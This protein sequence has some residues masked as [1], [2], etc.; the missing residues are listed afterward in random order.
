[1]GSLH[2]VLFPNRMITNGL[3]AGLLECTSFDA[4][5]VPTVSAVRTVF[6][7]GLKDK[8]LIRKVRGSAFGV[9]TKLAERVAVRRMMSRYWNNSSGFALDLVGAVIRQGSF[10]EKMHALDWLH[11]PTLASTMTHLITK[12]GRYFEILQKYPSQ[13]AVPTL[14][15]DLAWYELTNVSSLIPSRC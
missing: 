1:M 8:T 5:T 15:V 2:E 11:S 13:V 4:L 3:S 7:T 10:I 6:E 14:D 12:Y 9:R